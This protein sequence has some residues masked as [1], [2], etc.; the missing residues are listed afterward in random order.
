MARLIKKIALGSNNP[1]N[2]AG[3]R[4][5]DSS[6]AQKSGTGN[7]TFKAWAERHSNSFKSMFGSDKA[8]VQ[9]GAIH[10]TEE[11]TVRSA[12]IEEMEM[13]SQRQSM[14]KHVHVGITS[15]AGPEKE[16]KEGRSSRARQFMSDEET[17]IKPQPAL[18]IRRQSA[19]SSA[20]AS[21]ASDHG[22]K[23]DEHYIQHGLAR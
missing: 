5:F 6:Q 8:P 19:D 21:D 4:S 14:D 23:L 2:A 9:H 16:V 10:K 3:F 17:L 7:G 13:E 15:V 18:M 22:Q 12:P 20:R 1:Q 11:F